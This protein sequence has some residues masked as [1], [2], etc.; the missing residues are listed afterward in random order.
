MEHRKLYV[1]TNKAVLLDQAHSVYACCFTENTII[2]SLLALEVNFDF[3][4]LNFG[5]YYH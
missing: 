5:H 2:T 4:N 1:V 3:C